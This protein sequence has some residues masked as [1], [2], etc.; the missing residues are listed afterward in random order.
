MVNFPQTCPLE[1]IPKDFFLNMHKLS[2]ISFYDTIIISGIL[3]LFISICCITWIMQRIMESWKHKAHSSHKNLINM[4]LY[5]VVFWIPATY[6]VLYFQWGIRVFNVALHQYMSSIQVWRAGPVKSGNVNCLLK[7]SLSWCMCS[8][9]VLICKWGRLLFRCVTYKAR[10]ST[11]HK[12]DLPYG[13]VLLAVC[14][15]ARKRYC[16]WP[17]DVNSHA[18]TCI[19]HRIRL[20]VGDMTMSGWKTTISLIPTHH[21][22]PLDVHFTYHLPRVHLCINSYICDEFQICMHHRVPYNKDLL[23]LRQMKYL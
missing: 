1:S 7:L 12:Y 23:L 20:A 5:H 13:S 14:R 18:Y 19:H 22:P 11:I 8:K 9:K 16:S 2:W 17:L 3:V 4:W 15:S 10:L 21:S 6:P